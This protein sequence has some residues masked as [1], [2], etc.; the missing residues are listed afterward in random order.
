MP[1]PQSG[2]LLDDRW[3]THRMRFSSGSA[4]FVAIRVMR[5]ANP[6]NYRMGARRRAAYRSTLHP[7]YLVLALAR[8]SQ[9]GEW[10][11]NR[12]PQWYPPCCRNAYAAPVRRLIVRCL[13]ILFTSAHHIQSAAA[14]IRNT[15]STILHCLNRGAGILSMV[16]SSWV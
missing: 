8:D 6:H 7:R 13:N 1:A 12:L 11:R 4:W 14:A 9:I 5:N 16:V 3:P 10:P 15:G 2:T